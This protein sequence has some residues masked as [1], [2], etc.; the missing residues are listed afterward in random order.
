MTAIILSKNLGH[1]WIFDF[2]G[3]IVIHNFDL[4]LPGGLLPG[5]KD[6]WSQIPQRDSII[7]LTA[8]EDTSVK[9]IANYLNRESIR[10]DHIIAGL[11]TGERILLNDIKPNGLQTA[12]SL[13]LIR[14]K[15]ISDYSI[16]WDDTI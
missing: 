9:K 3:T 16:L 14:D 7:I 10:F 4:L 13:N 2:D 6:F 5:V 15:G 8:R 11:P 12:K 1:T